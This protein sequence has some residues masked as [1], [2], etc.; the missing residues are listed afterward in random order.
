MTRNFLLK[1]NELMNSKKL[2]K[3]L[4]M[5]E[6]R[7]LVLNFNLTEQNNYFIINFEKENLSEES[8]EWL[9]SLKNFDTL[10][11]AKKEEIIELIFCELKK[12]INKPVYKSKFLLEEEAVYNFEDINQQKFLAI[13][14]F[15]DKILLE[16]FDEFTKQE[17]LQIFFLLLK[18]EDQK[19]RENV[20]SFLRNMFRYKESQLK[21]TIKSLL[22]NSFVDILHF[23]SEP[24]GLEFLLELTLYVLVSNGFEGV[25][26]LEIFFKECIFPIL[27]FQNS[28]LY[29]NE[30]KNLFR[31]F[32]VTDNSALSLILSKLINLFYCENTD[33]K[34]MAV[35]LVSNIIKTK[36]IHLRYTE[37]E[38]F[39]V[40]MINM[41]FKSDHISLINSVYRFLNDEPIFFLLKQNKTFLPKIFNSFYDLSYKHW[42]VNKS[43]EIIYILDLLMK[44]N[45]EGYYECVKLYKF[46]KY[47]E[48]MD[49]QCLYD[50]DNDFDKIFFNE[51]IIGVRKKSRPFKK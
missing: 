38:S 9:E 18:N 12:F 36:E 47:K 32:S 20:S 5:H 26:E 8:N 19:I 25:Q 37:I 1:E 24:V 44:I 28:H 3:E 7:N 43:P 46:N 15:F 34:V 45:P 22:H 6:E 31:A 10:H 23:Q 14:S 4:E 41:C 33:K 16:N 48:C 30:L 21:N 42:N 51:K 2:K 40:E 29:F 11:T 27:K 49:K 39:L 13:F 17:R 50:E 35:N